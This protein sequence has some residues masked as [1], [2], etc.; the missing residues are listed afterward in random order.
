MSS[1]DF[2]EAQSTTLNFLLYLRNVRGI[3]Q[4]SRLQFDFAVKI[5]GVL[6]SDLVVLN[7]KRLAECLKS[8]IRF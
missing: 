2:S 3:S 8:Q 7:P 1:F 6:A 5:L 4:I